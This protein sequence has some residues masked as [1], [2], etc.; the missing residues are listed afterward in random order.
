MKFKFSIF[1]FKFYLGR[2]LEQARP[3]DGTTQLRPQAIDPVAFAE[4]CFE[5]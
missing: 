5:D 3:K 1:F 2:E 4:G